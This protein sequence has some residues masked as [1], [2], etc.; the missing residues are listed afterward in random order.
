MPEQPYDPTETLQQGYSLAQLLALLEGAGPI[1]SGT[2]ATV[3]GNI[4]QNLLPD[5]GG[6][7][8]SE[9]TMGSI[10]SG[11]APVLGA[12]AGFNFL[13]QVLPSLLSMEDYNDSE[14]S[15]FPAFQQALQKT[16]DPEIALAFASLV[17]P[18][19]GADSIGDSARAYKYGGIPAIDTMFRSDGRINASQKRGFDK[20]LSS[21]MLTKEQLDKQLTHDLA[22]FRDHGFLD[23]L[24]HLFL[25]SFCFNQH[26][27]NSGGLRQP[28]VTG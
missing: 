1:V 14:K 19:T 12:Y 23:N 18:D 22:A 10:L 5:T 9:G 2:G 21:G 16:G 17:N 24:K 26:N 4:A 28:A 15:F 7:A 6:L 8:A 25:Y 11:A 3:A 13:D 27:F 20:I